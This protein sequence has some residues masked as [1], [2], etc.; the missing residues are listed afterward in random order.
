MHSSTI[1]RDGCGIQTNKNSSCGWKWAQTTTQPSWWWCA[2][3]TSRAAM[4]PNSLYIPGAHPIPPILN[5]GWNFFDSSTSVIS[6]STTGT[7]FPLSWQF[8]VGIHLQIRLT[9]AG[10]LQLSTHSH[11]VVQ[12]SLTSSCKAHGHT[13]QHLL[14][15]ILRSGLP[16]MCTSIIS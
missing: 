7:L 3:C 16:S 15:K 6:A 2:K 14:H 10:Q 9:G 1:Y 4:K 13:H 11:S 8:C 5:S 12:K